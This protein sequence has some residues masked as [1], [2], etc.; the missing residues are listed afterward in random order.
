MANA[1]SPVQQLTSITQTNNCIHDKGD[2]RAEDALAAPY[3]SNKTVQQLMS[4]VMELVL[5]LVHLT[6]RTTNQG[7]DRQLRV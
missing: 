3:A 6:V 4:N 5:S 1:T 2:G 7:A